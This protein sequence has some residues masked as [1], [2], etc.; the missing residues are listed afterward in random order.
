MTATENAFRPSSLLLEQLHSPGAPLIERLEGAYGSDGDLQRQA[1]GSAV[2]AVRRFQECYG[3]AP[4]AVYRVP[5]RISLNPHSEHQGAWVPYGLHARELFLVAGPAD[6]ERVT[7]TNTNPM[8]EERLGFSGC[9]ERSRDSAAWDAGWLPYLEA[10]SVTEE[11]R[12]LRDPKSRATGRTGCLNYIKAAALRLAHLH[13][14]AVGLNLTLHGEIPAGGGLS[15]SS[16]LVVGTLLAGLDARGLETC[17]TELSGLAGEAEWFVGTRGGSGDHASMLLGRREGLVHLRFTPPFAVREQRLSRF[18]DAYEL[19]LA[20]SG[21]RS[22]KSAEERLLFNRGIFAYRFAYLALRK[23]L[24]LNGHHPSVGCLGDLHTGSHSLADLYR[25]LSRLPAFASPDELRER[26]PEGFDGAARSCFGTA[27]PHELPGEI[28]LRGAA[29]YGLGRVDR[30]RAMPELLDVGDDPS[31][32]EFGR[33]MSITHDGDRLY[34]GGRSY[35]ANLAALS[36]DRLD[37]YVRAA[38][39]GRAAPLRDQP[40]Y[41]GASTPELDGMVDTAMAT[42]GVLG[43]GLMGAG[44]GGY[45]LILARAGSYPTV[46]EA[47]ARDYYRPAGREPEV[48][49][50]RPVAAAGRLL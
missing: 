45:I 46:R 25:L 26:F 19:I 31:M 13:G 15:S 1:L 2:R 29:A 50:W 43:A 7:V 35:T 44:G 33:L 10:P 40:G 18:P 41:Y 11:V 36:D 14:D 28:P 5:C 12:R 16:A 9:E 22:E 27:E 24:G 17:R 6:D 42:D 39:E 32:R 21:V 38:E 23:E 47:L 34:A 20:N 8:W 48:E 37:H 49:P 4:G 3:D 30:G